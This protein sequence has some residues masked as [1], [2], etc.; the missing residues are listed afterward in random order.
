MVEIGE[1]LCVASDDTELNLPQ[2]AVTCLSVSS[3]DI[4]WRFDVPDSVNGQRLCQDGGVSARPTV[5]GDLLLFGDQCGQL[6]ALDV[7]SGDVIWSERF[8]TAF[9]ADIIVAADVA[10]ACTRSSFCLAFRIADG[11]VLWTAGLL[12]SAFQPPIMVDTV[13]YVVD[14]GGNLYKIDRLTGQILATIRSSEN[15]GEFFFS[16]PVYRDGRIFTGGGD[17]FYALEAP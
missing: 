12:G 13:L 11:A 8:A 2:G 5:A 15:T 3:G 9:D 7:E 16:R 1:L 14:I 17:W 6:F 4:V 10:Y